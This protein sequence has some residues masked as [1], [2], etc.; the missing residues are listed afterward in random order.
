MRH[1]VWPASR[2]W[3]GPVLAS[4][5]L[6]GCS[7]GMVVGADYGTGG[8]LDGVHMGG[9]ADGY[10][11]SWGHAGSAAVASPLDNDPHYTASYHNPSF[12]TG[13]GVAY[14]HPA[15]GDHGP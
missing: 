10:G 1:I 5:L 11:G 2:Q 9:W 13:R 4:A 7:P 15:A 8:M 6:A 12:A 14:Y 3:L